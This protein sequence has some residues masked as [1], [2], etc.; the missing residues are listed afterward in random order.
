MSEKRTKKKNE[1]VIDEQINDAEI[2]K[3]VVEKE[4]PIIVKG[5]VKDCMNLNVRKKPST[6]SDILGSIPK[7]FEVTILDDTV[8]GWF[9]IKAEKIGTGFCM[10]KY[11]TT[12]L[13]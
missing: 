7:N 2:V 12:K 11:I 1:K 6:D 3:E 13:S 4:E 10:S 8:D 5:I 9:E